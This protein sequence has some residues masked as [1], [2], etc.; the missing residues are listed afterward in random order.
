MK[1]T[2]DKFVEYLQEDATEQAR[3]ALRKVDALIAEL[4]A[5]KAS[6][7]AWEAG[8]VALDPDLHH[9]RVMD[10]NDAIKKYTAAKRHAA[11]ATRL[12]S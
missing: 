2:N 10:A 11:K 6:I 5:A 9:Q 8:E 1:V 4:E 3:L 7:I 12:L